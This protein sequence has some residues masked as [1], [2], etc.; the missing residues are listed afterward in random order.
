MNAIKE[1]A[2]ALAVGILTDA[3]LVRMTLVPAVMALLGDKAGGCP[4]G[5][6]DAYPASTSREKGSPTRKS[7][8]PGPQRITPRPCTPRGSGWRGSSK[9]STCTSNRVRC[10]PSSDRRTV[11]RPSCWRS[12]DGCPWITAG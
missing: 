7:W 2:L 1:I 8:P 4:G 11:S 3:F 6:I 12:G 9:A 10:K 5:W